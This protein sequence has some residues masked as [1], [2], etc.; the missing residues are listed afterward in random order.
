MIKISTKDI[1]DILP[2]DE[3]KAILVEKK[4]LLNTNQFKAAYS[5]VDFENK[6]KEVLTKNAYLLKKFGSSF[7]KISEAIPNFVQCDAAILYDRRILA[8]YPNGE[9]GIFDRDGELSWSG[10]FKYHDEIVYKAA[11]DG[12]YFW[13]VCPA[14]NCV[15][16]YACQNMQVD[17][18]L[19]GKEASTFINPTHISVDDGNIYVCA[20]VNKVR[21]IDKINFTVSDYLSFDE[22]I[23][24]FHKFGKY[25]IAVLSSGTYLLEDNG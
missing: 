4:P 3:K 20:G 25:A 16:R 12:K 9:A 10:Y 7:K 5:V 19:G 18:R 21:K 22:G 17:L 23:K 24:E 8:I 2:Y 14:E 6:T 1:I 13:S 15:I 11:L